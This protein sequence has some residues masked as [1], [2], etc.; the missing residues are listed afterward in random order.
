MTSG[1]WPARKHLDLTRGN[2]MLMSVG[3]PGL[4]VDLLSPKKL[5]ALEP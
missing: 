2:R 5:N 3:L 4:D 1:R